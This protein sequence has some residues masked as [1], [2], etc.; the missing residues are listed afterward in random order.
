MA[1][2]GEELLDNS[3]G[4]DDLMDAA[5]SAAD[6]AGSA[7]PAQLGITRYGSSDSI[8]SLNRTFNALNCENEVFDPVAPPTHNAAGLPPAYSRVRIARKNTTRSM[9][10]QGVGGIER[11]VLENHSL[12][13][14]SLAPSHDS[15]HMELQFLHDTEKKVNVCVTFKPGNME[16]ISCA[17]PHRIPM[18]RAGGGDMEPVCIIATDQNSFPVLKGDR[19]GHC[20]AIIRVEDGSLREVRR[21]LS[22]IFK[23]YTSEGMGGKLPDGSVIMTG[24]LSHLSRTGL[25]NYADE[26]VAH[27]SAIRGDFGA[28]VAVVPAV[29]MPIV[30][31]YSPQLVR[32]MF[33]LDS[34]VGNAGLSDAHTASTVRTEYWQIIGGG[35][36]P[37]GE[38]RTLFIPHSIRNPRKVTFI[39][40]APMAPGNIRVLTE[41]EEAKLANALTAS[42][43][44]N[45]GIPLNTAHAIRRESRTV[46]QSAGATRF[47][48]VGASHCSRIAGVLEA[49]HKVIRLPHWTPSAKCAQEIVEKIKEHEV[50]EGD[51]AYLDFFSNGYLMGSDENGLPVKA[52]PG[53]DKKYHLSGLVEGAP[54]AVLR[55]IA[56]DAAPIVTACS[57]ATIV[58]AL[59]IPRYLTGPCCSDPEHIVNHSDD[60]FSS[61]IDEAI[62]SVGKIVAGSFPNSH[63]VID[64]RG[65]LGTERVCSRGV[66]IFQDPDPVHL[67]R[68]AY[69]DLANAIVKS[70]GGTSASAPERRQR[71]TSIITGDVVQNL[72]PA[73]LRGE[74]ATFRQPNRGPP[75]GSHRGSRGSDTWRGRNRATPY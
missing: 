60:D 15:R 71:L 22:D 33:D 36:V 75:R 30:G 32:D 21:V 10:L 67:T 29:F 13:V 18:P 44:M 4:E 23:A 57:A 58:L 68:S 55:K 50:R 38:N 65:I 52:F 46:N 1:K 8:N 48:M 25:A 47:F 63:G 24:S 26:L 45:H 31:V 49:S 5:A 37:L 41:G 34:W 70:V 72:T 69:S 64:S 9:H 61:V 27:I 73:W 19:E 3:E 43:A 12:E 16:C 62:S 40:A 35:G 2:E 6:A 51:V 17:E 54:T 53:T 20:C 42:I 11:Q 59:P 7:P 66:P 56:L 14:G 28:G 74:S 39:S